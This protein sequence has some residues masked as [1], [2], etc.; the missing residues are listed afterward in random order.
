MLVYDDVGDYVECFCLCVYLLCYDLVFVCYVF[1]EVQVVLEVGVVQF[2]LGYDVGYC[3]WMGGECC[4]DVFWSCCGSY[5]GLDVFGLV[6]VVVQV[7]VYVGVGDEVVVCLFECVDEVGQ[8]VG[9][10]FV[11]VVE[12]F[13]V[14]GVDM[15]EVDVVGGVQFVGGFMWDYCELV[16]VG[17]GGGED[18]FCVI[19]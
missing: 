9:V 5:L 19:G 10:E 8:C 11:V 6:V 4:C 13:D 1:W 14:W 17:S 15:I 16:V 7:G 2:G 3:L 18:C 12:E